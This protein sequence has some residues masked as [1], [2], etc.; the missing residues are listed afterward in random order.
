MRWACKFHMQKIYG[1]FKWKAKHGIEFKKRQTARPDR[2]EAPARVADQRATLLCRAWPPRWFDDS[3]RSGTRETHGRSR[4][5]CRLSR[6]Y[7]P[8]EGWNAHHRIHP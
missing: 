2:M 1:F 6:G 7:R 4:D 5:Y 8:H 3:S